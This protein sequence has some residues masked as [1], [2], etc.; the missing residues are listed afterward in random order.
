MSQKK[1]RRQA[2]R[3][4]RPEVAEIN[5]GSRGRTGIRGCARSGR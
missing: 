2:V 5:L 3:T 1:E 4:V